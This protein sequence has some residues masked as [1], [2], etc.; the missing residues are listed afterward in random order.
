ME[1]EECIR[2]ASRTARA[3][4]RIVE[5]R[6]PIVEPLAL[7]AVVSLLSTWA[8]QPYVVQALVQEGAPAQGAAQAALWLSGVVSPVTAFGKALSS[9]VVCWA[10]SVFL[11]ERHSFV[12]LVSVFSVAE[13][14]FALR[15]LA[16]AG[17]LVT[18][19][20]ASMHATSDLMVAFGVNAFLH[21]PSTLQRIGFES[22]DIFTVVWAM[23]A[24][25]MLRLVVKTNIRSAACL[26]AISFALRT[27]FSAASL[28]YSI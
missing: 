26:A 17:V 2:M 3:L 1:S 5:Q 28:L 16:M 19:G 25:W 11:D 14:V 7:I 12:K 22:W 20:I 21:A 27:L 9:A 10:C 18:R 23:L 8:I 6:T 4:V 13:T 15:D 24:F